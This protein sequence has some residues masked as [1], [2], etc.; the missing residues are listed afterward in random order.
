MLDLQRL[1]MLREVHRLGTLA[2]AADSMAYT[3]SAISHQLSLL[4]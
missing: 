2:R 4:E 3:P 1:R